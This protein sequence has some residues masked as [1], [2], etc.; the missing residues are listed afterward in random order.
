MLGPMASLLRLESSPT[1]PP[2]ARPLGL[3]VRWESPLAGFGSSLR[4]F[5]TN[6]PEQ[7]ESDVAYP[8]VLRIEWV[9]N[10]FPGLAFVASS[11]WHVA[12][13]LILLLPIWKWL[14]KTQTNL[15]PVRIE[16]TWY[17]PSQDLPPLTLPG[18]AKKPSPPGDPVKPLPRRGADVYH[19]RQTILSTPVRVTHPRQTLIQPA[20][21]PEPPKIVPQIPNIV[22]WAASGPRP[23]PKLQIAPT[24]ASPKLKHRAVADVAVPELVNYEKNSGPLNVALSPTT[25]PMPRM[26][27]N[28][29]S[30]PV[31]ERRHTQA[32]PGAAP[33]LGPADPSGD[34]SMH[35]LIALS[36]TP[37][38]PA[39]EV[40]VPQGNL[41]A[42]IAISPDGKQPGVSSGAENGSRGNGGAGG[43]PSAMGG[44][45]GA[46]GT[47]TGSGGG[48]AGSQPAAVSISGGSN[49]RSGIAGAG[50]GHTPG[51]LILRPPKILPS[52]PDPE[53]ALHRGPAV[54]GNFD[55][56]LPP[57]KLL[58]GKEIYTMHVNMPNL[59]SATGSWVLH[60]AQLDEEMLPAY[61]RRGALSGPVPMEKADPKYP[62][63]L[64]KE[65]V[66]GDVVLYAIIRKNGSVDSIQLV[67][68]VDPELDRNA[69]EALSRWKFRPGTREGEP[70]DVEAV[71][72]IPFKYRAAD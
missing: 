38:P 25:N 4:A 20:A 47:A 43:D 12:A 3:N 1:L 41:A 56:S 61:K 71:V 32:D 13:V 11:L 35:R 36:A 67:R 24:A 37:G 34:A 2:D 5:F 52:S 17:T 59:T 49:Q 6:P 23:Q 10:Q 21:P 68:G 44:M 14:P 58:S 8:R 18:R 70:I 29:M 42:R 72:R 39:P 46:N 64:I 26:P 7:R 54:V 55:P 51:K 19:P 33:E 57:E 40:A 66:Q 15:A 16:L 45:N 27:V 48:G 28:P 65:H 31:A 62:P 69:M 22:E 53:A 30:T 60:C 50:G 9:Q 63:G